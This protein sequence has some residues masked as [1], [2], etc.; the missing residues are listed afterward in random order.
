MAAPTY[1]G[2]S[3][4]LIPWLP[5]ID[6]DR[7]VGCGECLSI[8]ANNVYVLDEA[9]GRMTV[10]NPTNCVVMC[11]TCAGF[12]PQEAISFPD[13]DEFKEVLGNLMR[14]ARKR[15]EST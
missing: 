13:K 2:I 14:E 3:R 4:D 5:T 12:C 8:C 6:P 11:D 1:L 9:D 7:C 10:A 15:P